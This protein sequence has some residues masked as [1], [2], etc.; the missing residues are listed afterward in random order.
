MRLK[1]TL[2]NKNT[3]AVMKMTDALCREKNVLMA[4]RLTAPKVM[5]GA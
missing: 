5:A 1:A 2:V 4:I 3:V